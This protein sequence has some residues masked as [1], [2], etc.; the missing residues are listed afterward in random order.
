MKKK[1]Q[2]WLKFERAQ[3]A[4]TKIQSQFHAKTSVNILIFFKNSE[5]LFI[6]LNR[7]SMKKFQTFDV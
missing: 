7:F 6:N 2:Y 1:P 5:E 3:P 4:T